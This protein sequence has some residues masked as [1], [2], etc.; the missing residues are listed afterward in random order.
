[1]YRG[2]RSPALVGLYLFGD[3]CSGRIW[4]LSAGGAARQRPILVA[5]TSLAIS[6]FGEDEAGELYVADYASGR[7]YRIVGG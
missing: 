7:I 1:V 3:Y 5:D 4:T 2:S 6:A